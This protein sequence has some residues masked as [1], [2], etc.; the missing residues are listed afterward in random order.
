MN[1]ILNLKNIHDYN[2][3]LG[4]ET[5]NPLISIIDFSKIKVLKHKRKCFGFYGIYLKETI[6]GNIAYGRSRY[7]YQEGTL[8]FVAPGQVAGIDDEGETLNPKGLAVL[9]HPDLL[10]NT[11]LSGKMKQYTFFSYEVNEALHMSEREKQ[12]I[13]NSFLEIEEELRHSADKHS[14]SIITANIEVLLNHCMRF[15]DRQFSTRKVINKDVLTRF[16]YLMSDYFESDKPQRIGL[17]SVSYCAE[18]L[19]FSPNYFGDLIKKETGKSAIEFI[20]LTIINKVKEKL[21]ETSKT[22]SEIAYEIGFQ[23]PHHLS[24]M[25]KKM[26]GCNPNE[27]RGQIV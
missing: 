3:F 14:K 23:Y 6:H 22:V 7:D 16:E 10:Q 17:P 15:Y 12:I 27:Y 11:S 8:I 26:V 1:D 24:R 9:F 2:Q 20:H 13:I 25:F 19:H 21:A 18:E 5:L 4:L